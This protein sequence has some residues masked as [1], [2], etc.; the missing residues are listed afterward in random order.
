MVSTGFPCD[1]VTLSVVYFTLN[2]GGVVYVVVLSIW[3]EVM[4]YVR[5]VLAL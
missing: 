5:R 1:G 3:D 4:S 2:A